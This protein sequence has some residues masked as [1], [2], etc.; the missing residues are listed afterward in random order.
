MSEVTKACLTLCDPTDGSPPGSSVHGMLQA[1]ILEWGANKRPLENDSR[2][3]TEDL[4]NTT[5]QFDLTGTFDGTL[6]QTAAE[7]K[8][9]KWFRERTGVGGGES[10]ELLA[11]EGINGLEV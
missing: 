3:V 4:N 6:H 7:H 8:G 9:E 10:K 1:I 2:K 11:E 5:H